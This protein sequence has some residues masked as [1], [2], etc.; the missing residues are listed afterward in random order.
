MQ[1]FLDVFSGLSAER[2]LID[3]SNVGMGKIGHF[4]FFRRQA[5]KSL[6]PM[7]LEFL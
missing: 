1:R 6:W 4:G 7:V 2:R 3:P 5:E